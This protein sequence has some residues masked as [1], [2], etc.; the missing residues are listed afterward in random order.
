MF[1]L[2]SLLGGAGQLARELHPDVPETGSEESF[3]HLVW[4]MR[5]LS[6]ERGRRRWGVAG[7]LT[8]ASLEEISLEA[9]DFAFDM[10]DWPFEELDDLLR[11][12]DEAI[13]VSKKAMADVRT[14][15]G[16]DG[17]T[18]EERE[19]KEAPSALNFDMIY[20]NS[21]PPG[22]WEWKAFLGLEYIGSIG[23]KDDGSIE[24]DLSGST[25]LMVAARNRKVRIVKAIINW[26]VPPERLEM[27]QEAEKFDNKFNIL[28]NL[29]LLRVVGANDRT[30]VTQLVTVGDG[31]GTNLADINFQDAQ[32]RQA[33]HIAITCIGEEEE[34]CAMLRTLYLLKGQINGQD[35]L[36]NTPLHL[37]ARIGRSEAAKTLLALKAHPGLKDKK[38]R[39]PL[40]VAAASSLDDVR[41]PPYHLQ[42]PPI[43]K[44]KM[45]I[46]CTSFLEDEFCE[47]KQPNKSGALML[48]NLSATEHAIEAA[49]QAVLLAPG[50]SL[51][52]AE[53][54]LTLARA[55]R[56]SLDIPG[57]IALY[58][59]LD[60][61][62]ALAELAEAKSQLQ[63]H[64]LRLKRR[65]TEAGHDAE[66]L[67]CFGCPPQILVSKMVICD[68]R[69]GI[70]L[71]MNDFI[72]YL[73]SQDDD[74][75]LYLFDHCFGE[76]PS[77]RALLDQYDDLL[78]SLGRLR[79]PYRWL[80]IGPKRSGS[81][82]HKDPLGTSAWNALISGRKLWVLFPPST[83]VEI[84]R[85]DSLSVSAESAISWFLWWKQ[86]TTSMAGIWFIQEPGEIVFVPARWW[87]AVLNLEDAIAVTQNFCNEWNAASVWR[88]AKATHPLLAR[89][90]R[91]RLEEHCSKEV[92]LPGDDP[93]QSY[94]F[95]TS[96]ECSKEEDDS[97]DDEYLTWLW[98][99]KRRAK[100]SEAAYEPYS[101]KLVNSGIAWGVTDTVLQWD[102]LGGPPPELPLRPPGPPE[103]KPEEQQRRKKFAEMAAEQDQAAKMSVYGSSALDKVKSRADIFASL[104]FDDQHI[105]GVDGLVRDE[106][107][108]SRV[109]QFSRGY[110][111]FSLLLGSSW[112]VK[113][114]ANFSNHPGTGDRHHHPGGVLF[115][116]AMDEM[117]LVTLARVA[118][119]AER[120]D[121]M[122]DFMKQRV[123][124]GSA[125][126]PEERDMFSAAFKNSLT[127]RRHAV[128][129]AA[130]VEQMEMA[131]G[132]DAYASL[133][134]GYRSKM[135]AELQE[136]CSN[137]L[138]LLATLV[139]SSEP[140]EAKTFFLKM[141][142]DY[143]R[144][145][146]E[147]TT[148]PAKSE[149]AGQ[150][151]E[152]YK[153]GMGEAMSLPTA[154]PVRL[155]LAL[156]FSVFLH[157]V[158]KDTDHAVATATDALNAASAGIEDI[159]EE[160][161]NDS[162][163]TMQLLNDN[164][165]LWSA[166]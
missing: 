20:F 145:L 53:A 111:D 36:G 65:C 159:P 133:A 66:E 118:E 129:V 1:P 7:D 117:I 101:G 106:I 89:Q 110:F 34:T 144:Y 39:T 31:V 52:L 74:S 138:N 57:A 158:L 25:A 153:S 11:L 33:A 73:K 148:G 42:L 113:Q 97:S 140:G 86:D 45:C 92:V 77:T 121:E 160:S 21:P 87:H 56:S 164:L 81:T 67:R 18:I 166:Q 16:D 98:E 161:R 131:E 54:Q 23:I 107:F 143:Y 85:S 3:K 2:F 76:Y 30:A 72:K 109:V 19:G 32:G 127:E 122:A 38:G 126:N 96:A 132:R 154:H 51:T 4:A 95:D 35:F 165:T 55:L 141:Q 83:P 37:A 62:E 112:C 75:P 147:W 162:I 135:E 71:R 13:D 26:T 157:E 15:W 49:R 68:H 119:R 146:A 103:P 123:Q 48:D 163:I 104:G 105:F 114:P 10:R 156:N 70:H 29:E 59:Q 88:C 90:L 93:N 27:L 24:E 82:L 108:G 43:Q 46:N 22:L 79:P 150:A 94:L 102:G 151:M 130:G 136:I 17:F 100:K 6:T 14:T 91:E 61:A 44:E 8:G 128:R 155:G 84:L 12:S 115:S 125:L 50:K 120:Y 134:G 47:T 40:M 78:A 41:A 116:R 137:A 64:R 142:G 63:K 69:F 58:E 99:S 5:E 60:D 139:A 28:K 80:L 124:V 152:V 9:E 149:V